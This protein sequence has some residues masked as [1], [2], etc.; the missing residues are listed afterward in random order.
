MY[1]D[2]DT[3]KGWV[4]PFGHPRI[5]ACSRLPMAFRSVPRPS[6]PPG[7]KAS[8]ECPYRAPCAPP[9]SRKTVRPLCHHAQEPSSKTAHRS[10]ASPREPSAGKH[11]SL[12]S[13]LTHNAPEHCRTTRLDDPRTPA[14]QPRS[15]PVRQSTR[16]NDG[17]PLPQSSQRQRHQPNHNRAVLRAQR[18][19][20]TRFTT[21]KNNTA[22]A[23]AQQ[24][25]RHAQPPHA[26]GGMHRPAPIEEPSHESIASARASPVRTHQRTGA[27]GHPG[28]HWR[29]SDSNR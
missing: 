21:Q 27:P 18:R 26:L 3:P 7:A 20:R 1:S 4:A 13:A 29:L 2:D 5:K 19:T 11:S 28:A 12:N 8:T 10:P 17:P 15:L 25:T 24:A 6:S 23:L 22:Q 16:R 9:N 14:H